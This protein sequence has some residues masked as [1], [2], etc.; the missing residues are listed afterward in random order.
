MTPLALERPSFLR[1]AGVVGV[2]LLA[3]L[4][5]LPLLAEATIGDWAGLGPFGSALRQSAALALAAGLLGLL[6]G[7]PLGVAAALYS[8]PGRR[9]LL[10]LASLPLLVPSLLWAIGWSALVAT[11]GSLAGTAGCLLVFT[12]LAAPL[13][14]LTA[15]AA[16][17]TLGAAPV[18]AAR[19][20]GGERTLAFHAARH[21]AVPALLAAGLAGVLVLADPGPGQIFG[22]RTAAA[23]ILVSFAA[24]FDFGLAARQG[25]ALAVLVLALALPLAVVAAPRLAAA[26]LPG[27]VRP[28]QPVRHRRLS[29]LAAGSL[30]AFVAVGVVAPLAGLARPALGGG[31]WS[32]AGAEVAATLGSTLVYGLGA[33]AVATLFGLFLA[34]CAGRSARLRAAVL[35]LS[36]LLFALPPALPALGLLRW[37]GEVPA[38]LDP[39]FQSRSMVCLALGLRFLPVAAL[40]ALR[41]WA[42]T[43]PTWAQAAALHGVSLGRYLGR[44]LA[45]RLAPAAGTAL[46]LVALLATADV[47]TVLL[48]HPPGRRSLPLA[49]FTI[50]AN[51]PEALVAALC[52]LYLGGAGALLAAVLRQG[53][54]A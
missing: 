12:T 16:T 44:V 18:E 48:L 19:L 8:F 38:G 28:L 15:W 39:I 33:G 25:L 52:L 1:A 23:E 14:L 36:F 26:V 10:G 51:A 43:S 37:G 9:T 46:L 34:A 2:F 41:G 40:L 3:A 24:L 4:P 29:A 54:T 22:Q 13:V 45:P 5:S 42:S 30:A 27:Q 50:M 21:A 11:P 49:L 7:L 6:I 53:R 47:G 31:A 17:S 35:A 20:A 32:R